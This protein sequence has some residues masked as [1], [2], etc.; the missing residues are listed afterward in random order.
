MIN[1]FKLLK[2]KTLRIQEEGK[3]IP[4][5]DVE[6]RYNEEDGWKFFTKIDEVWNGINETDEKA[7]ILLEDPEI[8]EN[9]WYLV[10]L[11]VGG[12]MEMP[13][14]K[15]CNLQLIEATSQDSA[16]RKYN[17]QNRCDYFYGSVIAEIPQ[18][19]KEKVQELID[20]KKDTSSY[21]IGQVLKELTLNQ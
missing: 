16:R 10:G 21:I 8:K 5:K 9:S 13:E 14:F 2:G 7:E 20:N 15:Y 12:L 11:L 19:K 4:A 18:N 3:I 1:L 6:I 17:K